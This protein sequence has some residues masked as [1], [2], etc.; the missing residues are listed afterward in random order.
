MCGGGSPPPPKP[1]K[2]RELRILLSRDA[3]DNRRG[4]YSPGFGRNGSGY[5]RPNGGNGGL[6]IGYGNYGGQN[7]NMQERLQGGLT[8]ER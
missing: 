3:Y 6:A 2:Q 4:M 7:S 8:I 1:Q 5:Y